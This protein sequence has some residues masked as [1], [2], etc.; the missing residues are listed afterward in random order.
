M[1]P[2]SP[3]DGYPILFRPDV[4]VSFFIGVDR[5]RRTSE[6]SNSLRAKFSQKLEV[7]SLFTGMPLRHGS[8][9]GSSLAV[10]P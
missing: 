2:V 6:V 8:D 7:T 1:A 5:G 4:T 10:A 3:D 9:R